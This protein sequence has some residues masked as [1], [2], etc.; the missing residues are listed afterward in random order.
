MK[1]AMLWKKFTVIS[2]MYGKLQI[3]SFFVVGCSEVIFSILSY[4]I[5]RHIRPFRKQGDEGSP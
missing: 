1:A 2:A 5:I 3:V 4:S